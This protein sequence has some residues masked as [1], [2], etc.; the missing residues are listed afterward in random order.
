MNS[1]GFDGGQNYGDQSRI[2]SNV[3]QRRPAGPYHDGS[4]GGQG[5]YTQ[6]GSAGPSRQ[7]QYAPAGERIQEIQNQDFRGAGPLVTTTS[8]GPRSNVGTSR[9]QDSYQQ[10]HA[11]LIQG[12]RAAHGAQ[13]RNDMIN[14]EQDLRR[15]RMNETRQELDNRLRTQGE[16]VKEAGQAIH[17]ERGV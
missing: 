17:R 7:P 10:N 8:A 11:A 12:N 16:Q 6:A 9:D 4:M 13:L 2:Q 15:F 14:A 3:P 1:G 5:Y